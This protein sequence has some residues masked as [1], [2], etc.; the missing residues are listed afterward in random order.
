[1]HDELGQ[2]ASGDSDERT[3]DC[4]KQELRRQFELW[5]EQVEQIP[6]TLEP[7]DAP[8]LYSLYE[9]FTAL[10]S[11]TRKGNRK[12]AEVISQI[13]E[14]LSHVEEQVNRLCGQLRHIDSPS[15]D[16]IALSRSYLLALVEMLD[17]IYRLAGALERPPKPARF[18]LLRPDASWKKAW[19]SL[20]QAVFILLTHFEKLLEQAGIQRVSTLGA[21]LDPVSMVAV[22][23]VPAEGQPAN[24]VV[25]EIA[26]GYRW[27]DEVL[28]PA[29]VKI[30]KIE[31]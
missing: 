28:R 7:P 27:H 25:E 17:R 23:I 6:E 22:A 21:A 18:A 24:I 13:G 14:S 20:Q 1:M 31:S 12:S 30:T 3:V 19:A 16:K 15:S 5:L 10:R 29:E 9:E 8:D 26:P 11:E 4:W 2:T